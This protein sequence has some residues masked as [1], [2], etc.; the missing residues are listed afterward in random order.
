MRRRHDASIIIRLSGVCVCVCVCALVRFSQK[1]RE[2]TV[3]TKNLPAA[4]L[5]FTTA[6]AATRRRTNEN[7]LIISMPVVPGM[8]VRNGDDA[9]AGMVAKIVGEKKLC[10]LHWLFIHRDGDSLFRCSIRRTLGWHQVRTITGSAT[11]SKNGTKSDQKYS[12]FR[13]QLKQQDN[14][15]R[16]SGN[17]GKIEAVQSPDDQAK[18]LRD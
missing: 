15:T 6:A 3:G 4:S 18:H 7:L 13:N 17:A 9:V 1:A 12:A 5:S 2:L 16:T 8:M 14:Q 10:R 11:G